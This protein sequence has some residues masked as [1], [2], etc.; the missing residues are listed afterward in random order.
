MLRF[1][2]S[3]LGG[4][5]IKEP[6]ADAPY[7]VETPAVVVEGAGIVE[8]PA[9]PKKAKAPAKPKAE[10]KPAEKKELTVVHVTK[11]KALSAAGGHLRKALMQ[12]GMESNLHWQQ[13]RT[14]IDASVRAISRITLIAQLILEIKLTA[15]AATNV[16]LP[17]KLQNVAVPP[18]T[19]FSFM[20]VLA[21]AKHT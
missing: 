12:A 21:W 15:A 16:P 8:I 7:K 17:L 1:F 19:H 6:E 14:N 2:K 4:K 3:L 9:T 11:V 13:L 5:K 20:A 18:T 10:K